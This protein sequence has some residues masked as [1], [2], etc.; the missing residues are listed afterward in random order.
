[1]VFL[2]EDHPYKIA[3]SDFNGKLERTQR[4]EIMTPLDWNRA[5]DTKKENEMAE[6]FDSNGEPMFNDPEFIDT[7]VE[8][9]PIG[10]KRKYVFYELPYW[11]NLK[12]DYFLDPM[13]ILKNISSSLWRHT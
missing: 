10:M 13:D 9:I 7:Y 6:L 3:T 5:Y 12:I 2:P 4:P 8:K 1:M 11:E